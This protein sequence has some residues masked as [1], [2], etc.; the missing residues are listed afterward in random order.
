MKLFNS[1]LL[2]SLL[3]S[4]ITNSFSQV[5][6]GRASG[7]A[8]PQEVSPSKLNDNSTSSEVNLF[9]GTFNTSHTLG[10]VSTPGGLNYTL[11]LNN[12]STYTGG[13][14]VSLTS[15]IPYGEGWSLNIPTLSVSNEVYSAYHKG[16]LCSFNPSDPNDNLE[17]DIYDGDVFWYSPTVS[18]PGVAS[19]Q[20]IFK[21]F[22]DGAAVFVLNAFEKYI[23]VHLRGNTWH[24]IL[25][26]GTI[27][28]FGLAQNGYSNGTNRRLLDEFDVQE[29]ATEACGC[30]NDGPTF[31][32]RTPA[33]DTLTYI[34][35]CHAE[36]DGYDENDSVI[37]TTGAAMNTSDE[38]MK[39]A[40]SIL[41]KEQYLTWYCT[42]IYN[43]NLPAQQGIRFL[44]EK[45]GIFNYYQEYSSDFQP[46][47]NTKLGWLRSQSINTGFSDF[48][49]FSDVILKE[50]Y[51]Y[52][53]YTV[54]E[55][56]KLNYNT[57]N[58][59]GTKNMLLLGDP[60]VKSYDALTNYK[61]V[62]YQ[63]IY[64]VNQSANCTA[65]GGIIGE[66]YQPTA[67]EY[68][69][70][71]NWRRYY[72]TKH[73]EVQDNG[74]NILPSSTNPYIGNNA[75]GELVYV[76]KGIGITQDPI[77]FNHSFLE[78]PRICGSNELNSLVPGDTYEIRT[79]IRGNQFCNIDVNLCSG[80]NQNLSMSGPNS[81]QQISYQEKNKESS[82][83]VFTT[84]NQAIKWNAV[85]HKVWD[86]NNYPNKPMY[87]SNYFSMPNLPDNFDGFHIQIGAANS[88]NLFN[89]EAG[90]LIT[91]INGVQIPAAQKSYLHG[92]FVPNYN[93]I[94]NSDAFVPQNFGV[95][96]PW[97]QML[98]IYSELDE[99]SIF[100]NENG[101]PANR[102]RFWWKDATD[103][104]N[105]EN[106]PTLANESLT[107]N[108]VE[109]I[110]YS[111][112]PYMLTSVEMYK[113]NG[114]FSGVANEGLV[115]MN[116][117]GL[118]YDVE[119]IKL[120]DN[121]Y[122]NLQDQVQLSQN[123]WSN[124]FYL[125]TV[126]EYPT[127]S[128]Q[129]QAPTLSYSEIQKL[130]S[131]HF[132]YKVI[133][134][135]STVL[136]TLFKTNGGGIV[137][138]KII[139]PLGGEKEIEYKD[140]NPINGSY[141]TGRYKPSYCALGVAPKMGH[142]SA[143]QV[144]HVV[145][146]IKTKDANGMRERKY[147]FT[148][149]V[150]LKM[151][152]RLNSEHFENLSL[153]F[154]KGFLKT[155]V[156]EPELQSSQFPYTIYEH[157]GMYNS[158]G[159]GDHHHLAGKIKSIKQY[160]SNDI[161]LKHTRYDYKVSLAY[162]NGIS[163][164]KGRRSISKYGYLIH[165]ENGSSDYLDYILGTSPA[166]ND[167]TDL[168]GEFGSSSLLEK[169][170]FYA[171]IPEN[172]NILSPIFSNSYFIALTHI[173]ERTYNKA[174]NQAPYIGITK[175]TDNEYFDANHKGITTSRGYKELLSS[176]ENSFQ[177]YVEP[178]WQLYKT[179]V[180]SPN[181]PGIYKFKEFF[182]YFD[183]ANRMIRLDESGMIIGD[184]SYYNTESSG[185]TSFTGLFD[186]CP[187]IKSKELKL[188]NI[189]FEERI[190]SKGINK[191]PITKSSYFIYDCQWN[192]PE[193]SQLVVESD[194]S[195]FC[196]Q[197]NTGT[198]E[199]GEQESECDFFKVIGDNLD[200]YA[201]PWG[202][203][204]IC[205]QQTP[206]N[207]Y[208]L[209]R[210]GSWD[211]NDEN[212]TIYRS[213]PGSVEEWQIDQSGARYQEEFIFKDKL[214]HRST[215]VQIDTIRMEQ[216]VY[217][218]HFPSSDDESP[219]LEFFSDFPGLGELW[220]FHPK[221]PYDALKVYE[222]L[223]RNRHGNVQLE[224]DE[225]GLKTSYHY[226]P[227]FMMQYL[228]P[229]CSQNN[230]LAVDVKNIGLIDSI[231]V[232]VGLAD[233]LVMI[234]DYYIDKSLSTIT[235]PN[236]TIQR[237]SY[238]EYNRLKESFRNNQRIH[239]YNYHF[240]ENNFEDDFHERA[241]SNFFESFVFGKDNSAESLRT[242]VYTDPLGRQ[243][244]EASQ[245]CAN[246]ND[247]VPSTSSTHTGEIVY[248][249]WDRSNILYKNFLYENNQN[250]VS[251]V[252]R[253]HTSDPQNYPDV[254]STIQYE[255]D[256]RSRVVKEIPY[257]FGI[258][259]EHIKSY[260]YLNIKGEEMVE[261]LALNAY[262]KAL[263]FE[264]AFY[265][266]VFNKTILTDEDGKITINYSNAFG[267]KIA[268]K[269]IINDFEVAITYFI[270]D[271]YGNI[272]T[273]IN[274]ERQESNYHYNMLGW[275]YQKETVDAGEHKYMYNK[276]GQVVL[277][278]SAQ[279]A[280]ASLEIMPGRKR[281]EFRQYL[282][283]NHGRL[284]KQQKISLG[285]GD[286]G[287]QLSNELIDP[288]F[289]KNI[290]L[291]IDPYLNKA[292]KYDFSNNS[293]YDWQAT[294][295]IKQ[296][297][298]QWNIQFVKEP[299]LQF[300]HA[301]NNEKEWYYHDSAILD[302]IIAISHPELT[303]FFNN[304][305]E[306]L[307][308]RLSHS[309]VYGDNEIVYDEVTEYFPIQ[310]N[311]YSY[312]Q[313]GEISLVK[314]QFNPSGI[315]QNIPGILVN[316]YYKYDLLGNVIEFSISNPIEA[317]NNANEIITANLEY[318][319]RGQLEMVRKN[320]GVNTPIVKYT[321]DDALGLLKKIEYF[322]NCF[323]EYQGID[324]ITYQYDIRNRLNSIESK[325]FDYYLY[326]DN[327]L[328]NVQNGS[329]NVS[330]NFNGNINASVAMYKTSPAANHTLISGFSFPTYYGYSY[331]NL[332]RLVNADAKIH[333]N[334]LSFNGGF[335][336]DVQYQ[337][338][339]IGN[340]T[341]LNRFEKKFNFIS[342][343]NYTYQYLQSTNKL[344]EVQI[345]LQ[346]NKFFTYDLSGNLLSDNSR[347][348]NDLKYG[349][350][351]LSFKTDIGNK[352]VNYL[353]NANDERIYKKIQGEGEVLDEWEYYVRD[354]FG[355]EVG[356]I[357]YNS[358]GDYELDRYYFGLQRIVKTSFD[359]ENNNSNDLFLRNSTLVQ[360]KKQLFEKK[361]K[362]T[363]KKP[364]CD[365]FKKKKKIVK[366][367]TTIPDDEIDNKKKTNSYY[368]YDHLGNTRVVYA[369]IPEC[370]NG[371]TEITG[372]KYLVQSLVDYYPYGKVLRSYHLEDREKYLTTHH[373]RDAETG[374]DYRMARM[375]DSDL[376]RF[377]SV[378]P[379]AAEMPSWSPYNFVFNNPLGYIDP[380]GLSP[381]VVFNSVGKNGNKTELGR[382]VTDEYKEIINI[383]QNII[384][385]DLPENYEPR[386]VILD[387]ALE[388]TGI[389]ALSV[390]VSGEIAVKFGGQ[391]EVSLIGIVA[392]DKKGDWGV[393]YQGNGLVGIEGSGTVS[394]SAY[395]PISNGDLT[396]DKLRGFEYGVQG[397][398]GQGGIVGPAGSYFEGIGGTKSFPFFERTYRGVS[399]GVSF[400]IPELSGGS[401]SGYIG[402]SDFI[403]RSDEGWIFK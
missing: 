353:Y 124:I 230:Y 297:I 273:V 329:V 41:P 160:N 253:L 120:I 256:F 155:T 266:Y 208:Y 199:P 267:Q 200:T 269:Q 262:E 29:F 321:Y 301:P 342:S 265:E 73:D 193:L 103:N 357:K 240:W 339:K 87:T 400:G 15:G 307:K 172:N 207:L 323:N 377:L 174:S 324:T 142:A 287:P 82:T 258:E 201:I 205:K 292:Y 168:S 397:S 167:D 316:S 11:S 370:E 125:K 250:P 95:G 290:E 362:K 261:E 8:T 311:F 288:L 198:P 211:L 192:T 5:I 260:E 158:Y 231:V 348:I 402:A 340:I 163:R 379:L 126:R 130:P 228:F 108:A 331:D 42:S 40:S 20:L 349:R 165:A 241:K 294:I 281:P 137:L 346:V 319:Y 384:P 304:Q 153:D 46:R 166:Q 162:E 218:S 179:T 90:D 58:P 326:Y 107:L 154:R 30:D 176:D 315:Q 64:D 177:L 221:F 358:S 116:K 345:P 234:Y 147:E 43:P 252:P 238:D 347:Q 341:K 96:L 60:G 2:F 86:G 101:Y 280:D 78:S 355:K 395:W 75:S 352:T 337:Y 32:V 93:L 203:A 399:L 359:S 139:S 271:S 54:I 146:S 263:L 368:I 143:I 180:S 279:M 122:Y 300:L 104:A 53:Y 235:G 285:Q 56:L 299:V 39:L 387:N 102:F 284:I 222:V 194:D 128:S 385:F 333:D 38:K 320:N 223:E 50:V 249:N 27:Y 206:E 372:I 330:N 282:Y 109:L 186:F 175:T 225:K 84:F 114:E 135:L 257:G 390:N 239:K 89:K 71:N 117:S 187:M 181:T 190:T 254:Y 67:C 106:T 251:L 79:V 247:P 396:L 51:S 275:L 88:D 69:S 233:S 202:Y 350:S 112:N 111:K 325:F 306:N 305:R 371:D 16:L 105:I 232:G 229:N 375:Y 110:R 151:T 28:E 382:I 308:G 57:I 286:L 157:F 274:P 182:Y 237:Y 212:L 97:M 188:R 343:V 92:S 392:G 37:C 7:E 131:T 356:V 313:D 388:Y 183:L 189:V 226:S 302:E 270:Y 378:D 243:Y 113:V 213:N 173:Y 35:F 4:C 361:G 68:E 216:D 141:H 303:D 219:L 77:P 403:Y 191:A 338:D 291:V 24:A 328:P 196:D 36:C 344:N 322:Q 91:N 59:N 85:G 354:I 14:N 381:D 278:Q 264:E 255:N 22:S 210:F 144:Y 224:S 21:Y 127:N 332:N 386:K 76:R 115:L 380:L 246:A 49:T 132:A 391:V 19:G 367:I 298:S 74:W 152:G 376:V 164:E 366:V 217:L 289:Y 309:L 277:E 161:L 159:I 98:S 83:S 121:K 401:F 185:S 220:K 360:S 336:G 26:D 129:N 310:M 17:W 148:E 18:I 9:N 197:G 34:N 149:P 317:L 94:L 118:E 327:A 365:F 150:T 215:W 70:F 31:C 314:E 3:C 47:I 65:P 296:N 140:I 136:D 48:V 63:G 268:S 334:Y 61:S 244:N 204:I 171:S 138:S 145:E 312:N 80:E 383:D 293:T 248:D 13:N 81:I 1:F 389:Q 351:N 62:F 119:T 156:F 318:N 374:L 209:C 52:D 335:Y 393:T 66:T 72:H 25:D 369:A 6:G 170:K 133:D 55:K 134:P 169:S 99:P 10:S 394:G 245:Y 364:F 178:S 272:T 242:K 12:T 276:S 398:V 123:N 184:A 23:E 195:V 100:V 44:Y 295:G 283:D 45:Y 373:E 227:I 259:S 33:G 214:Q 363:D 236:G